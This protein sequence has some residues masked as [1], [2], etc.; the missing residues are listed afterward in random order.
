[1]RYHVNPETGKPGQCKAKHKCRFGGIQDHYESKESAQAAYEKKMQSN[2]LPRKAKKKSVYELN[3]ELKKA[4][5]KERSFLREKERL[6]R[7]L[8]SAFRKGNLPTAQNKKTKIE[9]VEVELLAQEGK[10][11]ALVKEFEKA[12]KR[13]KEKTL[14]T[15]PSISSP[16]RWSCGGGGGGGC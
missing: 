8:V 15:N 4:V 7:E 9:T 3:L 6:E 12:T 11:K 10:V 5:A 16:S 2:T 1:M 14:P 13:E